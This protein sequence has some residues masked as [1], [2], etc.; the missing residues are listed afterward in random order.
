[1]RTHWAVGTFATL[2]L[3][4]VPASMASALDLIPEARSNILIVVGISRLVQLSRPV[5]AVILGNPKIVDAVVQSSD[6]GAGR[7]KVATV[8]LTGR[9]PG[10]TNV[11]FL[12]DDNKP[13]DS[14]FITVY[15]PRDISE[16]E[17]NGK[18]NR[19]SLHSFYSY[20]CAP[21]CVRVQDQI[22][23]LSEQ[24]PLIQQAPLLQSLGPQ[25][26]AQGTTTTSP[27]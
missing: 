15:A 21:V 4:T 23:S 5:R 10:Q 6:G 17:V 12:D 22:L 1:M 20:N 26:P 3:L 7:S 25:P 2:V 19:N 16:V 27:E 9:R 14:S 18:G 13:I 8:V 24:A 11:M